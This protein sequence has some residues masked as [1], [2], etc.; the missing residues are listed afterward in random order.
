MG[1]VYEYFTFNGKSSLDYEVVISGGGTFKSPNRDVESISVPGR[2]GDLHIDNERF[3]NVEIT[4]PAFIVK[5]FK[6]NFSAF[7]A[8]L[9]SQRG[10]KRL[11]DTY[12]PDYYRLACF[13]SAVEPD[14]TTRNLSGSFNVTFDCDPRCFLK[15]GE[16]TIYVTSSSMTVKNPTQFNALPKIMAYG[17]GTITIN[18]IS[19]VVNSANVYTDI[20]CELQEAYKGSTSCNDNITLSNGIFPYLSPGLNTISYTGFS[21]LTITPRYWTI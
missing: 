11:E 20:D 19:I 5:A 8:F 14:M 1:L 3:N 13:K 16:K 7:K 9:L 2:N 17:T 12:H 6:E 4:Y 15:S 18:G 21:S 10:Y